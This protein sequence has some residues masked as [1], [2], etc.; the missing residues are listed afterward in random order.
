[1][2]ALTNDGTIQPG[3]IHSVS[4]VSFKP[5][6][7]TILHAVVGQIRSSEFGCHICSDVAL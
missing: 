3:T 7:C 2:T 4:R 6:S 1:M 5:S